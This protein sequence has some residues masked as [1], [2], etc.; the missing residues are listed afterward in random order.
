M[1]NLYVLLK[2]TAPADPRYVGT[3]VAIHPNG[4]STVELHGGDLLTVR[5]DT[6]AVGKNVFVAGNAIEAEA[7][8]MEI[9]AKIYV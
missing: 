5:G 2:S 1:T 6:V 4:T 9:Q 3:V 7:P 8:A